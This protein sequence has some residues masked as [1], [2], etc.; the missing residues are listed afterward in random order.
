M[1]VRTLGRGTGCRCLCLQ[2]RV[3]GIL[4]CAVQAA[5]LEPCEWARKDEMLQPSFL[6]TGLR[7][8]ALTTPA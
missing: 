1:P 7:I 8:A 2:A 6:A 4:S 3:E 5:V